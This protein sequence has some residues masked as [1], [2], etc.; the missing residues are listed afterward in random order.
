MPSRLAGSLSDVG[1]TTFKRDKSGEYVIPVEDAIKHAVI[2]F[3][4]D[5]GDTVVL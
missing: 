5:V 3:S 2:W 1:K 4:V